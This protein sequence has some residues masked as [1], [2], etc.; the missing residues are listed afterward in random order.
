MILFI[1][2]IHTGERPHQCS[3]CGKRFTQY[4][5]LHNHMQVI[6]GAQR[7]RS[8]VMHM[9]CWPISKHLRNSAYFSTYFWTLGHKTIKQVQFWSQ[10]H[11]CTSIYFFYKNETS[12]K[13]ELV[14]KSNGPVNDEWWHLRTIFIQ[15]RRT[16]Y[17]LVKVQGQVCKSSA[18]WDC[19]LGLFWSL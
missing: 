8:K 18:N 3:V 5:T 15:F 6:K 7:S 17:R 10:S 11:Y 16:V 9:F 13:R 4:G 12:F 14:Q 2:R 1:Y 19:P